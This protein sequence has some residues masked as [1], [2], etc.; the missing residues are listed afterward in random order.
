M[1]TKQQLKESSEENALDQSYPLI[2]DEVAFLKVEQIC[3]CR[4]PGVTPLIPISRTSF[5]DRVRSKEFP[6]PVKMGR[7]T[8]WKSDDI[9]QLII[10]LGQTA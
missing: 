7:S 6:Q 5:L 2:L 9:K 8:L 4:K 10:Q 1:M 3:D